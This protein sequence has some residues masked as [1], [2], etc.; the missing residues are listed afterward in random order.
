LFFCRKRR[1]RDR[2]T[3][4][5]ENRVFMLYSSWYNQKREVVGSSR[6]FLLCLLLPT[7]IHRERERVCRKTEKRKKKEM[8]VKAERE[9]CCIFIETLM[10]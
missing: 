7:E 5:E 1:G 2:E 9:G 10:G 8:C 3:L 4:R 6:S